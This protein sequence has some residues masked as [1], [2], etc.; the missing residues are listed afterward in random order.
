[1]KTLRLLILIGILAALPL[2][3]SPAC[4]AEELPPEMQELDGKR[5]GVQTGSTFD[6]DVLTWFPHAEI[7]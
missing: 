6:R 7:V 5:F 1:M 4:C 3:F 2:V